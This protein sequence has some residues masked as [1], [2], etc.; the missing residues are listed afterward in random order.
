MRH[1]L[2][3]SILAAG[4]SG[5]AIC[6][7][8]PSSRAAETTWLAL[9]AIDTAQTVQFLKQPDCYHEQDPIAARL[10]G[11]AHPP[12]GRVIA[13]NAVLALIHPMVSRW[14]DDRVNAA[15]G[16]DDG[17]VGPWYVGRIVWHTVSI[18]GTGAAV[19]GNFK[20]GITPF[21]APCNR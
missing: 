7:T 13:V 18:G 21:G 6:P 2:M 4:L 10:Y 3:L 16:R 8:E 12:A 1:I 14:L 15:E 5:C 11:G 20:R 9:D 19:V 17:S